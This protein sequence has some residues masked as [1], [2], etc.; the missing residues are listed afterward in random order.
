[1]PIDTRAYASQD[2][3]VGAGMTIM[4]HAD[5]RHAHANMHR[6]T[7]TKC[8]QS[9]KACK[10]GEACATCNMHTSTKRKR[11]QNKS[12]Q[13]VHVRVACTRGHAHVGGAASRRRD[14]GQVFAHT[15]KSRV[16]GCR[17]QQ[18]VP[19]GGVDRCRRLDVTR[20]ARDRTM[21]RVARTRDLSLDLA[22]PEQWQRRGGAAPGC[23][24]NRLLLHDCHTFWSSTRPSYDTP[25]RAAGPRAPVLATLSCSRCQ[26]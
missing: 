24:R 25:R 19:Y 18:S 10:T 5:R 9:R 2:R 12:M 7:K 13:D 22:E 1:M 23:R 21:T 8:K 4:L 20:L 11:K 6:S 17:S 16:H 15:C 14:P 26:A 3:H